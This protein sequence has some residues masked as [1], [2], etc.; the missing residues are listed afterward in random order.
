MALVTTLLTVAI[1]LG[2]IGTIL[3]LTTLVETRHLGPLE[4]RPLDPGARPDA[5]SEL[6][7]A[8]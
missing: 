2:G 7:G 4:A 5:G 1:I 3:W 8:A 6:R